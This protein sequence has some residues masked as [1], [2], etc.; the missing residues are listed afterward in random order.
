[1]RPAG[2][3]RG[4][5]LLI[6]FV[7]VSG[8]GL[9]GP[10][11]LG[12]ELE[13]DRGSPSFGVQPSFADESP[14]DPP[15]IVA[16]DGGAAPPSAEL[17][18]PSDAG[19]L[20]R[21]AAQ[22][23]HPGMILFDGARFDPLEHGEAPVHRFVGERASFE[24]LSLDATRHMVVQLFGAPS[25]RDR[26][27]LSALGIELLSYVPNN[28]YLARG[29]GRAFAEVARLP[30]VRWVGRYRPG[31]KVDRALGRLAAGKSSRLVVSAEDLSAGTLTLDLVL[32]PGSDPDALAARL[33]SALPDARI[34]G[35]HAPERGP[36][37]LVV[38]VETTRLKL[39][40]EAL[41]NL[42]EVLAVEPRGRLRLHNDDAAWIGQS[43]DVFANRDYPASATIWAQGL[44][45]E[46]EIIGL[47]D[48]GVD[49]DVCWLRDDAGLPPV[50]SVPPSGPDAGPIPVDESRRKIIGYNL[51]SS[52]Q[53]SAEAYDLEVGEAHGTWAAVS[54]VGDNPVRVADE[55]NP[56][57]LH[58]DAADGMAPRAK[59]VVQDFSDA[60]GNIVGL[61]VSEWLVLD[62]VF[63]QLYEAG[64]R[65]TT[66][67]WGVA[68]NQYDSLAYFADKAAWENPDHLII[69]SAG[70]GGPYAGSL[71]SP[72][73]AK[74]VMAVGGSDARLSLAEDLDPE[75]LWQFSSRGPT[76]DG[77]LK[78]DVIMSGH[79]LITGDSDGGE[80]G[81]TCDTVEATG[82]SFAAPLV[83]GYAALARQYYRKGFYPSGS[84][85]AADAFDPSAALVRA[86]I[87]AGARNMAGSAGPDLGPCIFDTCDT[88]FGFCNG[89]FIPCKEDLDCQTCTGDA[90]LN[91]NDDRECDLSLVEDDAPS[92]D[93]GWGRLHLDDVLF[94]S[95]D[96]RGLSAWDVSREQGV[97]TGESWRAEFEV[98]SSLDDLQIVLAWPDPPALSASPSYLVN[99][100]D[101]KV[102][103]PDG[104]V[105]WGNAWPTRDR[106]PFV[107][108]YTEAER[109]PFDDPDTVEMVRIQSFGV[110]SGTWTVEV[111]GESV[112]GSPWLEDSARQDFAVVAVGPVV[113]GSSLARFTQP[114]WSCS[115][116]VEVEVIDPN[117]GGSPSVLVS[118]ASGDAETLLLVDQGGGRFQGSLAITAGEV[119]TLQNARLEVADGERLEVSYDDDAPLTTVRGF[120][121]ATCS[122][123]LTVS[124]SEA[125]GGCDG[126]AFVDAGEEVDLAITLVNGGAESLGALS[127]RLV[128]GSPE[129]HVLQDESSFAGVPA[130]GSAT[131][132]TPFRVSLREGSAPQASLPLILV[133]EGEGLTQP[134]EV[135]FSLDVET[136]EVA[137][138]GTWTE[139]FSSADTECYD[140]DPEPTPG[141]WYW[142]DLDGDCST[143]DDTWRVGFC[144]GDQEALLP[145][146]TGQLLSDQFETHHRLVGPKVQLGAEGSK[147]YLRKIRFLEN[148][149]F[150]INEDDQLCDWVRVDV[151]TNRD[152]RLT[153]T[154]YFRDRSA[155]G[156][157]VTSEV[158]PEQVSEWV[159]PPTP[160][161]GLFQLIFE[162]AWRAP[163]DSNLFC[164]SS[165]G[166]EFSWRVDNI[167]IDWENIA[168]EDDASSCTPTCV[169]PTTPTALSA[170]PLESGG[171]LVAWDPV[172]DADHYVVYRIDGEGESFVGRVPAPSSAILDDDASEQGT[173]WRVEAVDAS[174]LCPSAPSADVA[175]SAPLACA[176][177]PGTVANLSVSDAAQATCGVTLSW[178]APELP[179]G[180]TPTY[181]VYRSTSEDFVPGPETL[182]V[183]GPATTLVDDALTS[184]WDDAGEPVGQ[185]WHYEV[186]ALVDGRE[187][188]GTRISAR[189]GG[190]R[191]PGTWSDDGGEQRPAKMLSLTLVDENG[192]GTGWS[193]SPV[194]LRH[195]GAWSYWSDPE[196][197]GSGSYQPLSC[198]ALVS[199]PVELDAFA[200]PEFTM[201][202]NYQLEFSWD[203][204]VVELSTDGVNFA[205]IEPL[206]GYPG[207]FASTVAP[208]CAGAGGGQGDWINGCDYPPTQG[209]LTGPDAGGISGWE[210]YSFDLSAY[211]GSTVTLRLMISSDCGT[212]G[213]VIVDDL[214]LSG[215][216]LPTSCDAGSCMPA[217]TFAG[218]VAVRDP[219]PGVAG[220]LELSWGSVESWGGGGPGGFEIYRDGV[221]VG[222]TPA[223]DTS[224]VDA[225]AIPGALHE[226]QVLAR[227]GGG[228][229]LPSLSAARLD[230]LDCGAV[231]SGSPAGLE[232]SVAI[233]PS[234][235]TLALRA[236]PV[237]GMDL[238]RFAWAHDPASVSGSPTALESGAPEARHEVVG[239]GLNYFYL[240]EEGVS[241]ACP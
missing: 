74:N 78:P 21:L 153:P 143:P 105:Y 38:G 123:A 49:P 188:A 238:Y 42:E 98:S 61:G 197:L 113:A 176:A 131:S 96:E 232:L 33:A 125:S 72:A 212:Q 227:S 223:E 207:S 118:T 173:L 95:G 84:E 80:T 211:A 222:T 205:P 225:G 53:A 90:N 195:N 28:A 114:L 209:A 12:A 139:D 43:Y 226:Y 183:E 189:P 151:F 158:Q 170:T 2:T 15:D 99:D 51:L 155:T 54:A 132:V 69:V 229:A 142:F 198:I 160:D 156:S 141:S 220:G 55:S 59:L 102:T 66:N 147:T 175:A 11:A 130:G 19:A 136:D 8:M 221:L 165:A 218:L 128:S 107:I 79:K 196:A 194:A 103:A 206:G 144:F 6:A 199:P 215:A 31:Y 167:E 13:V 240:V 214:S 219:D 23:S 201:W 236:T 166:D 46:G 157:D 50:S 97:A 178:E 224:F 30:G 171:V 168:R 216:L 40:V 27:A 181:R 127:A 71:D 233:S 65:I 29:S 25:P 9:L 85:N 231:A 174:G 16:R 89:A 208:P 119:R 94:F 133:V 186:R 70:N 134:R 162:A 32:T 35:R 82:T 101:L 115:G 185:V 112:P 17:F 150:R 14:V 163:F 48:T 235:S 3:P 234:G 145:S 93:Q 86:S 193:R 37:L 180:G 108:E 67:S 81:E 126:D 26:A 92:R 217:P 138:S 146:C 120:A 110:A 124:A 45:G 83:A 41:A 159:L 230:G 34:L 187:G 62:A 116:Q 152:K 5:S 117:A 4:A 18:G 7:I 44:M 137:S 172:A 129:L 104:T 213:G 68:G 77:R 100:L 57:A 184:G 169:A 204:L 161:A 58:H 202:V 106:Q 239:D 56:L 149:D 73:T 76:V 24:S 87:V 122:P 52:F 64:A 177:A 39:D 47:V 192:T 60:E 22:R 182:L 1:M 88:I 241:Q 121:Q 154:G 109:R 191:Q 63:N 75:N 140:G 228:C 179:C 36:G 203:G 20:A 91:C 111:V 190:P 148:Y 210:S 135:A 164:N 10:H 237:P 200:S